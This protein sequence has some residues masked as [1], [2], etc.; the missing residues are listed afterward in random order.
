MSESW[1]SFLFFLLPVILFTAPLFYE[2]YLDYKAN[3]K[4]KKFKEE[5][6]DDK[7]EYNYS[8]NYTKTDEDFE[9]WGKKTEESMDNLQKSFK[10]L[11]NS[12]HKLY[13]S[14]G[15]FKC[16]NQDEFKKILKALEECMREAGYTFTGEWSDYF[17]FKDKGGSN[18]SR[19][20][21]NRAKSCYKTEEEYIEWF[22][23][24][25]PQVHAFIKN[26]PDKKEKIY[27]SLRAKFREAG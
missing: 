26:N 13:L 21:R 10:D 9:N 19:F 16:K 17:N 1:Y 15:E 2:S 18:S 12:V 20:R 7:T 11:A 27:A 22:I 25:H 14:L 23:K 24:N 5:A 4:F 3:K 6:E 8:Y